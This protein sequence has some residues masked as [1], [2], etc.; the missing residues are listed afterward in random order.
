[1]IPQQKT[2]KKDIFLEG[3]GVHSG[4]KSSVR[5][6]PA[7]PNSGILLTNKSHPNDPIKIGSVI[8]EHAM[9]ATILRTKTWAVSTIEHLM[10]ALSGLEIDNLLVE[11]DGS[12]APIFDGSALPFVQA[13]FAVGTQEQ[14]VPR[15]FLTPKQPISFEEDGRF[16][17]IKPATE[18]DLSLTFDY[19]I[20]FDHPLVP[21]G[22]IRT[23]L[24]PDYFA[25]EIAPARTFGFLE[26]LPMLRQHGL[27]KGTTLGNTV[28]VGDEHVLN[29]LRFPDEFVRHKLLDLIGDLALAGK[30]L[31]GSIT[32]KK[33][34]HSFN[35][36]VIEHLITH[37]EQWK[38][39]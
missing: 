35:R 10:A 16:I 20:T 37:P 36:L 19:S 29:Q 26:Q 8:P 25:K 30:P 15:R 5:L 34:G 22:N 24:T 12:E 18:G 31:A 33:T 32:A 38:T 3:I 39:I 1:M 21:P 2:I 14:D 9:H 28:V 4:E 6:I 11:I 13:I 27:A 7:D 23:T 17:E